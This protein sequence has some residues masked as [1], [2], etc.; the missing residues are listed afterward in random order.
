MDEG[1]G[2]VVMRESVQARRR[3]LQ[4]QRNGNAPF[5][6]PSLH[7][8]KVLTPEGVNYR[9]VAG[10]V[11]AG[12][13]CLQGAVAKADPA[14]PRILGIQGVEILSSGGPAANDFYRKL[15]VVMGDCNWCEA[16][17]KP[18]TI[19]IPSGQTIH[20]LPMPVT[21]P[22]DLLLRISFEIDD[23]K[24]MGKF[25]KAEG[26][27]FIE[28]ASQFK[29]VSAYLSVVDPE[30]HEIVFAGPGFWKINRQPSARMIHAGFVVKDRA[31]MDHFYKDILGFRLYWSGGMKEGE[32]NWVAM[33]VPDGTDWV[34]YMLNVPENADKHTLG[35]MNHISLGVV[36]V[37][38]AE[39][40]LEKAGVVLGAEEQP[41]IGRDGKWQLNLYDPDGTRVELM[42]FTPV[43]KPCCSEFTGAHP[44]P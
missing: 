14:R 19:L 38:A 11:L 30:G 28:H 13:I 20:L 44:K 41:K 25:L 36:S 9:I 42:E 32:T 12:M 8:R 29:E 43:E 1:M 34:E 40:Q 26:V 18:G 35:V 4:T 16:I 31:A 15:G 37:K 39:K 2:F 27:P 6:R 33:Q 24:A 7:K 5:R 3:A 21:Q 23:E 10:I 22:S 17:P